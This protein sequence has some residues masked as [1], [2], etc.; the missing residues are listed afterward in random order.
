M[1]TGQEDANL[2]LVE[3]VFA[4]VLGPMDSQTVEAL[5][6]PGFIQHSPGMASG[7]PALKDLLDRA[8]ALYPRATCSVKRMMANGDLVMAHVHVVFEPGTPGMAVVNIFR[9]RDGM[10][11]EHW[12]VAQPV[13]TKPK[14]ANGMF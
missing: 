10:V 9:I 14:N 3:R 8:K 12:D 1:R 5:F 6:A 4:E 7:V 2:R 13:E 11:A